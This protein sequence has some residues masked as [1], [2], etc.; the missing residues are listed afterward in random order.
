[1]LL[2][3]SSSRTRLANDAK[4]AKGGGD[5]QFNGRVDVYR[6]ALA[7]DGIVGLYRGFGPSVLG[8][9]VYRR[10]RFFGHHK[11]QR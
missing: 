9:I 6:K 1:M 11:S 2:P 8:I 7:P 3:C 5:R 4:S 10:F